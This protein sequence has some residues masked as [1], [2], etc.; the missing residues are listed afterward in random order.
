M[1][2][3]LDCENVSMT[4]IDLTYTDDLWHKSL[5]E[6]RSLH[7][8]ATKI[9]IKPDNRKD[10][11]CKFKFSSPLFEKTYSLTFDELYY[12][13]HVIESLTN[14]EFMQE[15]P[16]WNITDM[17]HKFVLS[18]EKNDCEQLLTLILEFIE[19]NMPATKEPAA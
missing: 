11:Y 18:I 19:D 3:R 6:K 9:E 17:R 13:Y 1:K 5:K 8:L 16:L 2:Y 15:Y 4:Y 10:G 12:L 14:N 7:K